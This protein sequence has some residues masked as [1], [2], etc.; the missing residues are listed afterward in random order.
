MGMIQY[1]SEGRM[2]YI[3]SVDS[4]DENTKKSIDKRC[5][6]PNNKQLKARE[7]SNELK[8]LMMAPADFRSYLNKKKRT[9]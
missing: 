9:R 1:D 6:R 8:E 5:S 7:Q 4:L 2:H 3:D